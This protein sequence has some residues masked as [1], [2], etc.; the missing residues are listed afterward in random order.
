MITQGT[1]IFADWWIGSLKVLPWKLSSTTSMEIYI[2]L[3]SGFGVVFAITGFIVP[4]VSN[5]MCESISSRLVKSIA[6]SDLK[7]F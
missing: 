5:L 1:K 3:I 2:G 7:W 4:A 6:L